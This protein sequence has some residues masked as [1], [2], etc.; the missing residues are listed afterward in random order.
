MSIII[1]T[2]HFASGKK[3]FSAD[4]DGLSAIVRGMAIDHARNRI[5]TVNPTAFTDISTGV[6]AAA[7]YGFVDAPMPVA[8]FNAASAG[9][10]QC[11]FP[12]AISVPGE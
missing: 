3:L 1:K 12:L 5:K 11:R 6:A 8:A 7:P 2:K 9:G 4:V 10:A